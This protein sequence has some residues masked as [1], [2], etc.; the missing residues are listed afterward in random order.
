MIGLKPEVN[1]YRFWS[2]EHIVREVK[3]LVENYGVK[4]LKFADEMYF[5][6]AKHNN[7]ISEGLIREGLG[8]WLDIWS[9]ARVDTVKNDQAIDLARR[10]GMHWFC[11]GIESASEHVRGDINK[12]YRQENI[13]SCIEKSRK[14][15]INIIANFIAGLPEDNL[16]TLNENLDMALKLNTEWFTI[17]SAMAYPG[18]ELYR[19]AVRE[20]WR[21]PDGWIGYSQHSTET[22]PLPTKHLTGG[23][24]LGFRDY[25]HNR[26]FTNPDY[27]AMVEKKFGP[28]AIK[29]IDEMMANKLVRKHAEIYF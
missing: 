26:Y 3:L 20:G 17:Y 23:Q 5:L 19:R 24:V 14:A 21:L 22:L 28:L 7:G 27:L 9:Y 25:A 11:L 16:E 6:N 1:S 8:D 18:S 15:G 29:T 12:S 10:S 13:F 4:F 2:P